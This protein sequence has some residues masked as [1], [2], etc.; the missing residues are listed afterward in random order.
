MK[1]QQ[2]I[3][4]ADNLAS[5]FGDGAY[6]EAL[7]RARREVENALIPVIGLP[8]EERL[9]SEPGKR[10][11]WTRRRGI[12]AH[13]RRRGSPEKPQMPI[14]LAFNTWAIALDL[15]SGARGWFAQ[16]GFV[17]PNHTPR[18]PAGPDSLF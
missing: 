15:E 18:L 8:C 5:L 9:P 4:D 1:L 10:W 3:R 2:V 17:K 14:Q 16:S 11:G 13:K 7:A 12:R 6:S